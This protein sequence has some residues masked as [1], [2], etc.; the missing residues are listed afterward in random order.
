MMVFCLYDDGNHV[1]CFETE[2]KAESYAIENCS[3]YWDI[4]EEAYDEHCD[5]GNN[6]IGEEAESQAYDRAEAE[7]KGN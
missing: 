3:R 2:G 7:F 1:E 6:R 5:C 4:E